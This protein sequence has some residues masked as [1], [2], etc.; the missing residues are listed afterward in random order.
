MNV[1]YV[2]KMMNI[3]VVLFINNFLSTLKWLW[4]LYMFH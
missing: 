1:I 3:F 4:P 2:A